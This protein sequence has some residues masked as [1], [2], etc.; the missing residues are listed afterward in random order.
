M[1]SSTGSEILQRLSEGWIGLIEKVRK[2]EEHPEH[3]VDINTEELLNKHQLDT[4]GV[5][6]LLLT[7]VAKMAYLHECIEEKRR[8]YTWSIHT[9][10][11]LERTQAHTDEVF[12]PYTDAVSTAQHQPMPLHYLS[13][14]DSSSSDPLGVEHCSYHIP[15]LGEQISFGLRLYQSLESDSPAHNTDMFMSLEWIQTLETLLRDNLLNQDHLGIM[16]TFSYGPLSNR[17]FQPI[18]FA[19]LEPPEDWLSKRCALLQGHSE[20]S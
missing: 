1:T 3:G 19:L 10:L 9:D 15:E 7:R 12:V 11:K 13:F 2:L 6:D 17:V 16:K 4:R 8:F 5:Q 20:T 18:I 14:R